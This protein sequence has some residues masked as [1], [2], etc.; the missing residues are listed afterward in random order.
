MEPIFGEHRDAVKRATVPQDRGN[1]KPVVKCLALA[2]LTALSQ[3][4]AV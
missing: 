1:C 4:Q 3:P 2:E